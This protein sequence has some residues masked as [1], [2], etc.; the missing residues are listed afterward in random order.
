MNYRNEILSR[1]FL[2]K[3]FWTIRVIIKKLLLRLNVR[4]TSFCKH[5]GIDVRDFDVSNDDWN[6]AVGKMYNVVCWN[7]YCDFKY[8][9]NK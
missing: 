5:C 2:N 9:N 7:C 1:H 6:Q 8:L 3:P 4:Q